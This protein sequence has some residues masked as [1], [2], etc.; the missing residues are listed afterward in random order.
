MYISDL[1]EDDLEI[2]I[3]V[4]TSIRLIITLS[5]VSRL[6]FFD[7]DIL[8]KS[9]FFFFF[10]GKSTIGMNFEIGRVRNIMIHLKE[11]IVE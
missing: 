10:M 2:S 5:K 1:Y 4:N 3:K 8:S 11:Q 6:S 7:Q 9:F